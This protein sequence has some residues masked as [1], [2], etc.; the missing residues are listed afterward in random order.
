[1]SETQSINRSYESRKKQKDVS[2]ISR[3][4]EED[5]GLV[6]FAMEHRDDVPRDGNSSKPTSN[7]EGNMSA[8]LDETPSSFTVKNKVGVEAKNREM[9]NLLD[10]NTNS[11]EVVDYSTVNAYLGSLHQLRKQREKA[12]QSSTF[13]DSGQQPHYK[14]KK[15]LYSDSKLL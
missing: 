3:A 9:E 5:E 11:Q 2:K 8:S 15:I 6:G 4:H 13:Q 7:R 12:K 1:M 10:Q 14:N